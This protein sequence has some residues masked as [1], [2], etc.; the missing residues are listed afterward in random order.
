MASTTHPLTNVSGSVAVTPNNCASMYRAPRSARVRP[1]ATPIPSS[2]SPPQQQGDNRCRLRTHGEPNPDF[3]CPLGRGVRHHTIEAKHGEYE[4]DGTKEA[5]ERRHHPLPTQSS[6]QNIA[7]QLRALD[8]KLAIDLPHGFA[9]RRHERHGVARGAH[10]QRDARLIVLRQQQ[11]IGRRPLA[12]HSSRV[13]HIGN[14][15]NDDLQLA[16]FVSQHFADRIL[17][18]PKR[19][20]QGVGHDGHP[21]RFR[22]IGRIERASTKDRNIH[23]LEVAMA[24]HV[25]ANAQSIAV[26]PLDGAAIRADGG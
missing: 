25:G 24:D 11:I 10:V 20:R 21:R 23:R 7:E 17:V 19:L 13:D 26:V 4:R 12:L 6:I 3:R 5:D 1:I 9:N 22:T 18:G 2:R 15:A 14:D 16:A 8:N